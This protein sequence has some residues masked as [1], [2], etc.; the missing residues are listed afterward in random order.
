MKKLAVILLI[1][2]FLTGL[3]AQT[4]AQNVNVKG[5][6]SMDIP[7]GLSKTT[8]LNNLASLQ[9]FNPSKEMYVI[10]IDESVSDLA[11][12]NLKLSLSI[13]FKMS[14]FNIVTGLKDSNVADIKND[15]RG[16]LRI[17]Q[18]DLEGKL[19]AN[20]VGIFYRIAII[21][22]PTHFYQIFTWTLQSKKNESEPVF[23]QMIDS[24]AEVK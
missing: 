20:D 11:K 21:K 19:K 2:T 8:K 5:L 15:T 16:N 12:S 18:T 1:M 4:P 6:Y 9:Y 7:A 13:Y 22:S 23:Q 14:V 17:L 10:V 3:N 24:F